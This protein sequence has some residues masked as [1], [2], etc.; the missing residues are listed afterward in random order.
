METGIATTPFGRRPM[1]LAMLAAQNA[2]RETPKGRVVDK[3]QIYR[4]LCEGKSIIGIGDRALAVLNALLSFYPDSDL[5]EENG[6]IVFPSN[7]QLSLRAHGMPDSTLRRNLAELVDCGLVIRRD[8]PN[9]KR[10]ARKGRGGEIEEAFGFSLAPLLARAQEFEA[11]AERVR[12][13]NRALRLMRERITLHRRDIQKLIEAAVEEDVPGDWGGLWRHFRAV[14]ES[15]PRRANIAELEPIVADLAA[16]RDDVDKLL[17]IHMGSTIP[18]GNESQ[19]ERQQSDSNTDSIFEF[20]P[21]LEKSGAAAEP[22][23]RTAEPPKTYPLGLVLKACPEIADYAV[24]GIGN[25]RDFMITA[26]QVRGYLGVSPSAY[27]DA[28]HVMGQEIAAV[29]IAC[30]LQRAQRIESAGGYLRVLTEK[31]RA[32]EFSVGPMLMAALRANGPT[33]KMT[34]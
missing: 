15:I 1:S 22:L 10:Y 9:G 25:W 8:S 31:A 32:G 12:A 34:G 14:V 20:E 7:A 29:V 4:N 24:E 33:A 27:E 18:S 28:C 16:L 30:I 21:A 19:S 2:S 11:A 6:L 23:T 17:E 3:W 13:D 5:S 26:A